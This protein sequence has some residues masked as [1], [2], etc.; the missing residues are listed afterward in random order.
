MNKKIKKIIAAD[1]ALYIAGMG[2]FLTFHYIVPYSMDSGTVITDSQT[3]EKF[4]LPD[5]TDK[6]TDDMPSLAGAVFADKDSAEKK[7]P[8]EDFSGDLPGNFPEFNFDGSEHKRNLPDE[9]GTEHKKHSAGKHGGGFADNNETSE[10]SSDKSPTAIETA[11]SEI[12]ASE[13]TDTADIT[14]KKCIC[15]SGEDTVTYYL[16]DIY[17]T[18]A[19]EIKT[20]FADGRYGKNIRAGVDETAEENGAI[21][22]ISG[23]YYGNSEDGVV[24]RNGVLYRNNPTNADVC[25]LFSDGSMKT[26]SPDDFDADKVISEGA[27]QAWTFGPALLDEN[28]N[29]PDTFNT[30]SYIYGNNPRCAI[31]M[32]SPGHYV[33]VVVDG[34][35]KGY[36]RGVD[37]SELS[38]IM[39]DAGCICA[40]NLDGGNSSAMYFGDGFISSPSGGGRDISDIVYIGQR[41]EIS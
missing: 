17:V 14:V 18:S 24:I 8:P 12:I 28:G 39:R 11:S 40:Y 9:E 1:I 27:W 29:I 22:A 15:G 4:S 3:A 7:I 16:A 25:V 37:L 5:E 35:D 34:R 30:N 13:R 19:D 20:A 21:I 33:F 32:I 36:S 38:A 41:S 26:Y 31:G 2:T 23:D 6:K 10:I